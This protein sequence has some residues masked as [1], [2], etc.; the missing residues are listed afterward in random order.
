MTSSVFSAAYPQQGYPQ[1]GYP[2]QGYPQQ[3]YPQQG[4]Y[5]GQVM[6]PPQQRY[7]AQPRGGPGC[8]GGW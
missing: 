4:G 7:A 5:G 3:G 2:Q 8:C 6:P 1:Q